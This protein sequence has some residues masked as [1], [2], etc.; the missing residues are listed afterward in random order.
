[1]ESAGHATADDETPE[2]TRELYAAAAARWVDEGR[3]AH[4]VLLP[5]SEAAAVDGWFR[6]GFGL[7]QV[8]ALREPPTAP[9]PPPPAGLVVR[10]PVRE[11]IPVLARLDLELP[12]HHALSP[13]FSAAGVPTYEESLA[14]WEEDWGNPAFVDAVA[15]L[16]GEV[17]ALA[18]CCDLSLGSI[19]TGPAKPDRAWFL[20]FAA[21]LPEA[22]GIGAGRATAQ[23]V[24][25]RARTDP[26]YDV[27]VTDWREPNL[28]SSRAWRALGFRD[29][30]W[31]LHRLVDH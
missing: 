4:Y 30:F 12:R 28:T 19:H 10:A 9:P 18:A 11:D 17:V 6:V 14:Y 16:D 1:V 2:V 8:H 3:R 25:D 15:E 23:A 29:T 24:I 20:S 22:R 27:V 31:R 26:S 7:Q 13:T 5:A 21:V